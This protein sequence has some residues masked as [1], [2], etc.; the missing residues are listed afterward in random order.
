VSRASGLV[1]LLFTDVVG[2]TELSS[3]AEDE[4]AHRILLAHRGLLTRA[5]GAHGGT[6]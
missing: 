6:R 5:V 1:T 3:R 2:S 4:A